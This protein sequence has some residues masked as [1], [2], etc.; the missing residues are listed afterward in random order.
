[1]GK[2]KKYLKSQMQSLKASEYSPGEFSEHE[3]PPIDIDAAEKRNALHES[4]D[5]NFK[6]LMDKLRAKAAAV[7][8]KAGR[9]VSQN[10]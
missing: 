7:A 4:R 10:P 3:Y 8:K 2:V 6:A 5:P 1:M 9:T